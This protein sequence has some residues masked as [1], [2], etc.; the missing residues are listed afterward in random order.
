[1][2]SSGSECSRMCEHV[3]LQGAVI[4]GASASVHTAEANTSEAECFLDCAVAGLPMG[5]K[6][7]D[8]SWC[9]Q[10]A[11][12]AHGPSSLWASMRSRPLASKPMRAI[13]TALHITLRADDDDA[14]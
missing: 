2:G 7:A 12:T 13:V 4:V 1:M 3:G 6:G 11:P 9:P 5:E 14:C 10:T 8:S